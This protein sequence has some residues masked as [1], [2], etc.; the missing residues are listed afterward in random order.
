M[1]S[2]VEICLEICYKK[3]DPEIAYALEKI[4]IGQ[5]FQ[6]KFEDEPR[7]KDTMLK[8]VELYLVLLTSCPK[9]NLKLK[10]IRKIVAIIY[11]LLKSYVEEKFTADLTNLVV[12]ISKLLLEEE[13]TEFLFIIVETVNREW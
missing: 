13:R 5:S 2:Y 9:K 12:N 3:T 1:A 7:L 4:D 6:K 10:F 8:I 11:K